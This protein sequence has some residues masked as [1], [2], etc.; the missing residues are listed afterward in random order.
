MRIDGRKKDQLRELKIIPEVSRYAEG[1]VMIELGNTK[2]LCT[3]SVE[4]NVPKWLSGKGEGWITAEYG[5]L[6]RSTHTRIN[7]EKAMNSGRTQEISRLIGRSLRSAVD[8]KILGEKQIHVD[9]DV[10]QADGGTRT[11]AITGGFVALAMALNF[12]KQQKQITTN[13]L[14]FYVAAISVGLWQH[15]AI[16]D[17]NYDEDSA[18]E[19]D[20]NFVMNERGELIEVQGTAEG[21]PFTQTQ[22]I[23]MLSLAQKGCKEMMQAQAEWISSFY[24]LKSTI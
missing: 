6:P 16:L 22:L 18:C 13:P 24:E 9:C 10:I 3:A 1:S 12:M 14:R 4:Q 5:M 20:S 2:V 7:R 17:L 19:T 8:L 15:E 23:E 11:A 21:K